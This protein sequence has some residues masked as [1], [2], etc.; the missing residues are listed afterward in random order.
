M[1]YDIEVIVVSSQ[2]VTV[3]VTVNTNEALIRNLTAATDYMLRI[4]SKSRSGTSENSTV[5]FS[6]L[7]LGEH[8]LTGVCIDPPHT[9]ASISCRMYS[10]LFV[11]MY[12]YLGCVVA[13]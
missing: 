4:S 5:D 13:L 6:T 10:I 12:V 7:S 9:L 8:F 3:T 1:S 11:Y 2:T